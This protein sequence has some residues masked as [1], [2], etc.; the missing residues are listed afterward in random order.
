M[1]SEC[2][3]TVATDTYS[4][5]RCCSDTHRPILGEILASGDLCQK[6]SMHRHGPVC[7]G[8]DERD[9]SN[10]PTTPTA[11]CSR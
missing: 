4:N 1:V 10:G 3:C 7:E 5:S 6:L 2:F 11:S 8:N 9:I